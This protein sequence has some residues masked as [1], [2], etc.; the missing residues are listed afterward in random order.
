MKENEK[1]CQKS[2]V[3]AFKEHDVV[4]GSRSPGVVFVASWWG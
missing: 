4:E 2:T 3:K 1:E